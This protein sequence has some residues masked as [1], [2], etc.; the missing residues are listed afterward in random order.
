M[1]VLHL[2][3]ETVF[4]FP[5][6]LVDELASQG[7]NVDVASFYQS[8]DDIDQDVK[9]LA[10]GLHA[11]G[12]DSRFD[13]GAYRRF[14]ERLKSKDYDLV[15]THSNFNGSM[16][17]LQA[18]KAGI[19]TIHTEH[20]Q[21]DFYSPIQRGVNY[22]SYPVTDA[23]VANSLQTLRSIRWYG[24]VLS[25]GAEARVIHNGVRTDR[26]RDDMELPTG[27]PDSPFI[28]GVG[29]FMP[30]KDYATLLEAFKDARERGNADLS[31]VLVGYGD[32]RTKL[33]EHATSLGIRD[34]VTF[35]GRLPR[36]QVYGAINAAEVF[37]HPSTNEGFGMTVLEAMAVGTP[38]VVS[39]MDVMEEVLGDAGRYASPG[40]PTDFGRQIDLVLSD[41]ETAEEMATK[42][43]FRCDDRFRLKHTAKKYA[44]FYGSLLFD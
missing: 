7:V 28:I 22:L 38:V 26:I 18:S 37:V 12:A 2:M 23:L 33:E 5:V 31:L 35:T 44:R 13:L 17:R 41:P 15:H 16:M 10:F 39:S 1:R 6:E 21:H 42:A 30:S 25:S 27:L 24:K 9:D 20:A 14:S 8:E 32:G 29:R 43:Q 11:V 19:P 34:A 4:A 40:T 36:R 3:N